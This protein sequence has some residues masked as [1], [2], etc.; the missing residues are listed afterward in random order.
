M[1]SY[2]IADATSDVE[3]ILRD[4]QCDFVCDHWMNISNFH[5]SILG[6]NNSNTPDL[7]SVCRNV[8]DHNDSTKYLRFAVDALMC[9][10]PTLD[11]NQESLNKGNRDITTS[12]ATPSST[13][14]AFDITK[15]LNQRE[16]LNQIPFTVSVAKIV[17]NNFILRDICDSEITMKQLQ[18][19]IERDQL[20]IDGK[21]IIGS[22]TGISSCLLSVGDAIESC[23]ASCFLPS[24]GEALR[25]EVAR[26][27]LTS[28]SRTNSGGVALHTLRTITGV[29]EKGEG[30]REGMVGLWRS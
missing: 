30:G 14:L 7:P 15:P 25:A 5:N 16:F 10:K 20:V 22:N 11:L 12:T 23:L 6:P 21:R 1:S 27:V 13:T 26:A 4:F 17:A 19:D 3:E 18:K 2:S 9:V 29:P 24:L 28:V 8:S